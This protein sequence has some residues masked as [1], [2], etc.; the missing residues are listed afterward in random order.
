M[1]QWRHWRACGSRQNGQRPQSQEI[2]RTNTH[3]ALSGTCLCA[4]F[5]RWNSHTHFPLMN[6]V[7]HVWIE[8]GHN[9]ILYCAKFCMCIC[10][11]PPQDGDVFATRRRRHTRGECR[12]VQ[13]GSSQPIQHVIGATPPITAHLHPTYSAR[14]RVGLKPGF[15]PIFL[16]KRKQGWLYFYISCYSEDHQRN[17]YFV[18]QNKTTVF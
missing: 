15:H 9:I 4:A 11:F 7:V 14:N 13:G 10:S 2:Q 17:L 6:L 12:P 5:I 16:S 18:C 8:M 3:M 1:S